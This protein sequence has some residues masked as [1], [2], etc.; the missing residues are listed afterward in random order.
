MEDMHADAV[1]EFDADFQHDPHDIPNSL[2]P[3]IKEQI[4]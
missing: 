4:T 2:K 1:I 3:R